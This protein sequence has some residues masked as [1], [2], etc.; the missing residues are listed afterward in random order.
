MVLNVFM[1][2]SS[3]LSNKTAHFGIGVFCSVPVIPVSNHVSPCSVKNNFSFNSG[4]LHLSSN[5]QNNDMK[6]IKRFYLFSVLAIVLFSCSSG[7]ENDPA[8]LSVKFKGTASSISNGRISSSWDITEALIGVTKIEFEME[9]DDDDDDNS[10]SRI[11]HGGDDIDDDDESEIEIKGNWIVNLLDGT[12]DP[13]LPGI[14]VDQ[15][16]FNEIKVVL[17]PII[18]DQY[19][20]IF[21][22]V[23]TDDHGMQT[24]VEVMLSNQIIIKVKDDAGFVVTAEK[25]NEI[26][27]ELELDKWLSEI[28]LASLDVEN[29]KIKISVDHN[30]GEIDKIKI[31]IKS[32][33]GASD[34]DED[35][36]DD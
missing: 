21:N 27:I 24:P 31:N 13:E 30:E 15:G 2:S 4:V 20:V 8:R 19:S 33:C 18:D 6:R 28:D 16:D 23:F 5:Q 22:A 29:G 7:N 25:L 35:N 9:H 10:G 17:S 26:I 1:I 32:H 12:S 11:S 3:K 34:D 14:S 36:D